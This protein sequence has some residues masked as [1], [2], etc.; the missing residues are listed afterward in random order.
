MYIQLARGSANEPAARLRR[1]RKIEERAALLAAEDER[2]RE[3]EFVWRM[4][5]ARAS[6]PASEAARGYEE[7]V[8]ARIRGEMGWI[9]RRT[10]P[11]ASSSCRGCRFNVA[12]GA[13]VRGTVHEDLGF[14]LKVSFWSR[15]R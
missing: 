9:V 1:G 12:I 13:M 11:G 10:S 8:C 15:V 4:A 6:E 7:N 5:V 14:Y 2:E 3:E